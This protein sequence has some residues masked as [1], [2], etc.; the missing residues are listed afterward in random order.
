MQS[1][2][3]LG[4]KENIYQHAIV[5]LRLEQVKGENEVEVLCE[6]PSPNSASCCRTQIL[7]RDKEDNCVSYAIP[8]TDR[9]KRE[10]TAEPPTILPPR[11]GK[12]AAYQVEHV[13]HD[14]MKDLKLKKTISG[15]GGA[16]CL[17][18]VYRQKDWKDEEAILEG[19]A[20]STTADYIKSIY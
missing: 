9:C 4:M 12:G 11:S 8:Y 7:I 17:L 20:I 18:C 2:K 3:T 1:K 19:F 6:N 10:L 5:T 13:I 15:L 16:D 14:T